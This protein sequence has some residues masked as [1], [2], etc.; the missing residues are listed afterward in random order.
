MN[1]LD[2][3]RNHT[4]YDQNILTEAIAIEKP[5]RYDLLEPWRSNHAGAWDRLREICIGYNAE[6]PTLGELLEANAGAP[7][8]NVIDG[9][10]RGWFD[11]IGFSK[12]E[13]ELLLV[14][15]ESIILMPDGGILNLSGG[16]FI[17]R[18]KD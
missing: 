7:K 3:R 16:Y 17:Q 1:M 6:T 14:E 12:D 4:N 9:H 8:G 5:T 15:N 18:P 2:D 11:Q 13:G 10:G